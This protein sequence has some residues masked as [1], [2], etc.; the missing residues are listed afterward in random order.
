MNDHISFTLN[1]PQ[2]VKLSDPVPDRD[3]CKFVLMTPAE[4]RTMSAQLLEEAEK[5]ESFMKGRK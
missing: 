5:A 3:G 2:V 4:A 1:E